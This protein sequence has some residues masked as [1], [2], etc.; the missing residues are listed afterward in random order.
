[1]NTSQ[2]KWISRDPIGFTGGDWNIY[3]Y[4]AGNPVTWI[5]PYGYIRLNEISSLR[6]K[7]L[8][9]LINSI[10]N[11]NGSKA[12]DHRN[13]KQRYNDLLRDPGNLYP[14]GSKTNPA[15]PNVGTWTGHQ[16]AYKNLQRKLKE[17]LRWYKKNGCDK[18]DG[19]KGGRPSARVCRY[20]IAAKAP[21]WAKKPVPSAPTNPGKKKRKERP[22]T[23]QIVRRSEALKGLT[24]EQVIAQ[25]RNGGPIPEEYYAYREYNQIPSIEEI[26]RSSSVR[27]VPGF[28]PLGGVR[29]PV[30]IPAPVPAPVFVP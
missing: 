2:G 3:N 30:A 12:G 19:P 16:E 17:S 10:V 9:A 7:D 27:G 25:I 13:I 29:V 14:Y 24:R 20:P 22:K 5:D 26:R 21:E 28:N 11:G 6:C 1:L 8:A 23:R 4:V 18:K 15:R